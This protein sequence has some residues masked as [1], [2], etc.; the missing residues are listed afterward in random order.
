MNLKTFCIWLW[1]SIYQGSCILILGL[2][3]FRE[4]FANI[5]MITFTALIMIEILNVTSQVS[6]IAFK[7][8][9]KLQ[10]HKFTILIVFL[11]LLSCEVY[12]GTILFFQ[13]Y[14]DLHYITPE[15]VVKVIII[16]FFSWAPFQIIQNIVSLLDPSQ[17]SKL[18]EKD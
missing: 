10:I 5:V 16:T 3:F 13:Q 15:F 2:S 18:N 14:F 4:S 12:Y 8:I 1:K 17:N 11:Q 6:T 7:N 9:F